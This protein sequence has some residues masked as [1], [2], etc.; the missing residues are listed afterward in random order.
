MADAKTVETAYTSCNNGHDGS[1]P[2]RAMQHHPQQTTDPRQTLVPLWLLAMVLADLVALELVG[3]Q[4]WRDPA[5]MWLVGL[6]TSQV[7]LVAIWAGLR[8]GLGML[9]IAAMFAVSSAWSWCFGSQ[10]REPPD[11]WL[12]LF[13][14]ESA[15]ISGALRMCRTANLR[16]VN[17]AAEGAGG[18]SASGAGRLQFSLGQLLGGTA[19]AGLSVGT[20]RYLHIPSFIWPIVL[21][22]GACFASTALVA[23]WA[24]MNRHWR[25]WRLATLSMAACAPGLFVSSLMD[26]GNEFAHALTAECLAEALL[27]TGSLLVFRIGGYRIV[28]GGAASELRLGG[29]HL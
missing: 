2:S 7:G 18:E 4:D 10:F 3:Q 9:R 26:G 11:D 29:L 14:V 16:L 21:V 5:F 28:L 25:C 13:L 17:L 6:A 23:V 20:L 22:F 19:A 12:L 27:L 8:P 24:T 1:R 15:T